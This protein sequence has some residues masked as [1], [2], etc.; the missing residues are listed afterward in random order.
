M[1]EIWGMSMKKNMLKMFKV[2][3]KSTV[4]DIVLV[5]LLLTSEAWVLRTQ[6]SIY[7]GALFVKIVDWQKLKVSTGF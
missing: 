6:S 2:N 7:N 1:L 3:I 4:C 5:S